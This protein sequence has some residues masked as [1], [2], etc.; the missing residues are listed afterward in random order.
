MARRRTQR[1]LDLLPLLDV[2]MVILF[3]FATIQEREVHVSSQELEALRGEL[4]RARGELADVE[5]QARR[6]RAALE[7]AEAAATQSES[8]KLAAARR[9][10]EAAQSAEKR[11]RMESKRSR[12]AVDQIRARVTEQLASIGQG[13]EVVRREDVLTKLLHQFSVFEIDLVGE[14]AADGGVI[15]HCCFRVDPF[16]EAWGSCGRVPAESEALRQWI[17]QGAGGLED[18]LRQTRG[19]NAMTIIRQDEVS[20]F[21][22]RL[23]IKVAL[24]ERFKDHEIYDGGIALDR[25]ECGD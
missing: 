5:G 14:E 18:A 13:E 19:G 6:D 12:E 16:V 9:E 17:R 10:L 25:V 21:D 11:A 23:S 8:E 15:N 1:A 20:S 24:Q 7:A 22:L 3:V 4:A 2:F